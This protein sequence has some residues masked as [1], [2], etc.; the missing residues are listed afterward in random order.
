MV[1]YLYKKNKHTIKNRYKNSKTN[2]N[3]NTNNNNE[4]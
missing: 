3:T 1:N 2:T 4:I